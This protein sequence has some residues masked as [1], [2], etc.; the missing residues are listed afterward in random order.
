MHSDVRIRKNV[1]PSHFSLAVGK[2]GNM[3]EQRWTSVWTPRAGWH[4]KWMGNGNVSTGGAGVARSGVSGWGESAPPVL[5][6][7]ERRHKTIMQD[8]PSLT[9]IRSSHWGLR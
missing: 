2:L 4:V 8:G 6:D 7:T 3:R 5:A 1:T 9:K